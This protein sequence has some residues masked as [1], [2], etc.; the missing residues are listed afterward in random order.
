WETKT[1]EEMTPE[2]WESL[3]DGCARCCLY[4][5]E[6]EESLEFIYTNIACKFLDL[7]RCRCTV[8]PLRSQKM[9]TCVTLT[10]ENVYGLFW[11]PGTCAY[12]LLASGENLAW[13]HPLVSGDPETVR[14]ADISVCGKA[15]PEENIDMDKL[16]HHGVDWIN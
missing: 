3:C 6:E 1:F 11:L 13:W 10:P 5:I 7:K 16:E 8:Y 12:K 14:L 9:P 2:E 4:K 15:I